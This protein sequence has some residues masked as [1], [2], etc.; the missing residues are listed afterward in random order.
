LGLQNVDVE[1]DRVDD[2]TPSEKSVAQL[3]AWQPQK[4]PY[5]GKFPSR[6]RFSFLDGSCRYDEE[7]SDEELARHKKMFG[8]ETAASNTLILS[9]D[10]F[11]ILTKFQS[12]RPTGLIGKPTDH[13]LP[14]EAVI[15][16]GLGLRGGSPNAPWLNAKA[17]EKATFED[18]PDAVGGVILTIPVGGKSKLLNRWWMMVEGDG[19]RVLD[20]AYASPEGTI[21][22]QIECSGFQK[23]A[24]GVSLPSRMVSKTFYQGNREPAY[25]S[26][27]I[28]LTVSKY[29]DEKENAP[30]RYLMVWP[31]GSD[32]SDERSHTNLH[33]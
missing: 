29:H 17:L 31:V 33:E 7:T 25:C 3:K 5:M 4:T 24:A 26:K 6:H 10:R 15:D 14:W 20:Y 22:N 23:N 1:Y 18:D 30:S 16:A 27:T 19:T 28:T 8:A 12:S 11:E 13:E 21:Y 2:Y 9:Q 32:V